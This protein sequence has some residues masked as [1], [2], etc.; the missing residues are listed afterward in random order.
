M[1]KRLALS[2]L[3]LCLV[4]LM[5]GPVFAGEGDDVPRDIRVV[6]SPFAG[7]AGTTIS[8]TGSGAVPDRQVFVS[9]SPRPGSAEGA[10]VTLTVD[11]APDG[12]FSATLTVPDDIS[13]GR[14]FV[15]GEQFTPTG[16]V[17][18]YYYNDFIIGNPGA[19]AY[20]PV[21]GNIPGTSFTVAAA[22]A[23][24][25]VIV[26]TMRGIYAVSVKQ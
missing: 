19:E 6:I 12:T 4:A 23:L 1:M 7:A 24:L 13:D 9:L 3:L 21:T 18:H 22:M 17:L 2:G 20:L 26:L 11:P 14:Y 16:N 10:F 8:V 5:A 15:R 25:L